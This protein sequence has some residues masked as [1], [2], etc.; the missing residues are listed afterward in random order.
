MI[1]KTAKIVRD[2]IIEYAEEKEG[3]N[4]IIVSSTRDD[5]PT[6]LYS[7]IRWVLVGSE[8][9]LQTEVKNR[10]V[11]RSALTICQNIMYAFKTRR[12]VQHTPKRH[13]VTFRTPHSREN[14]Q[15]LGLALTIHHD[16]R[17]KM[18][19]NL[20]HVHNYCIPYNRTLHLETAIA[21]AVVENTKE[22]DGLYVPPFL[23]KGTFVFFAID[24]TDFAED[25]VD[26]KGTTH[27]TIT[28][29]YQKASAPGEPVA[30]N[31]EICEAHSLSVLPYHV[32]IKPCSKPKPGPY[33]RE[34]EFKVNSGGVA[35]SYQLNTHGWLIASAVS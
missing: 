11:D 8:E 12:Q 24:N 2:S 25:T 6:E 10:T 31:L 35:E 26:G 30:H 22:F 1:Y 5:I 7:L 18:L 16:T 29:V 14:P 23:K 28:A 3:N 9:Q 4:A 15:V 17:N 13:S 21:N 32:P 19:M 27:G 33:K 20:L 34:H